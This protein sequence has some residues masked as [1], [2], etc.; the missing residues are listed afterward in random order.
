MAQIL[1]NAEELL[2]WDSYRDFLKVQLKRINRET[3]F[4]VS[5]DKLTFELNG[6]EWRGHAVLTG[7][8]ADQVVRRMKKDGL[9]FRAGLCQRSGR[10]V[11]FWGDELKDRYIKE[12]EKTFDRLRLGY[13]LAHKDDRS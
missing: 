10:D 11:E 13:T 9:I 2:A 1:E 4:F 7:P 5:K 8:K 12:A 3:P 6:R